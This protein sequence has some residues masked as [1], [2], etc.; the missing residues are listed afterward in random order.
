VKHS[1][2]VAQPLPLVGVLLKG[3]SDMHKIRPGRK[4]ELKLSLETV[5]Q[6]S[7][8]RSSGAIGTP[9]LEPCQG[10]RMEFLVTNLMIRARVPYGNIQRLT[11]L[12]NSAVAVEPKPSTELTPSSCCQEQVDLCFHIQNYPLT[13]IDINHTIWHLYPCMLLSPLFPHSIMGLLSS[14]LY[15]L[16]SWLSL[17]CL[18]HQALVSGLGVG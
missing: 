10:L 1:I 6:N 14:L 2:D 5:S 7:T 18:W 11:G 8:L 12:P 3:S 16:A 4:S 9:A 13:V 15:V 17:S